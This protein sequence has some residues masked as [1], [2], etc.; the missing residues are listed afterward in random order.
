MKYKTLKTLFAISNFFHALAN[1]FD[2]KRMWR[3]GLTCD[4]ISLRVLDARDLFR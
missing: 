2:R 3:A 1:F 4:T